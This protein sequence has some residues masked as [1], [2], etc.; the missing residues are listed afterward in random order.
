[1]TRARLERLLRR[2]GAPG[3]AAVG[4][5]L[6][7]AAFWASAIAPVAE[8]HA[9]AAETL[10]RLDGARAG[11]SQSADDGLDTFYQFFRSGK[12]SADWLQRIYALARKEGLQLRQGTYRFERGERLSRYEVTLPV[13]GSY[14]QIRRFTADV[15]NEVPVAS[16]DGIGFERKRA[17]DPQVEA[18]VKFTLFLD[19]SADAAGKQ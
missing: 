3:V 5:L 2:L 4:I 19:G 8:R 17:D 6:F 10:A 18:Q 16:L 13:R 14:A 11:G 7:C 9:R 1:M 12:S 15:L